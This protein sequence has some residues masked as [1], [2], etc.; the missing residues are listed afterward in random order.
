[1]VDTPRKGPEAKK[2][3][4]YSLM[5]SKCGEKKRKKNFHLDIVDL[6]G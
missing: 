2:I 1:M 3:Y 5:M 6:I 4:I